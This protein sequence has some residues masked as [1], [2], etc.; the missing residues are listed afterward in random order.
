MKETRSHIE[1]GRILKNSSDD[2]LRDIWVAAFE[3]W[4]RKP[5]PEN[6]LALD[7]AAAELR[8]RPATSSTILRVSETRYHE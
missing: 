8:L 2:H 4:F 6:R 1:R 7:D 3:L 5:T